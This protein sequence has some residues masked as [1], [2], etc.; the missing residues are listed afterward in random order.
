MTG[1]PLTAVEAQRIGL[2]NHAL[3]AA[4]LDA[5]VDAFAKRLA[6]GA[7]KAISW[8]KQTINIGLRQV[9][10]AVMD[11]SV[12]YEALS[13]ITQD[14]REAVAAMREKRKPTFTGK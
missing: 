2:I 10:T 14:H 6:G 13:N 5:A 3:P 8:T 1:D 9:A 7:L 4:E 11:A 12:A